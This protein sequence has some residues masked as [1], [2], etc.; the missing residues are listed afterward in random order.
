MVMFTDVFSQDVK[1]FKMYFAYKDPLLVNYQK[2]C[3]QSV[4]ANDFFI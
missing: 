4:Y 1:W 3:I 2:V